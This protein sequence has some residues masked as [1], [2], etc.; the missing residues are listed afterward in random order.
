MARSSLASL[1][2]SLV[3]VTSNLTAYAQVLGV[4]FG[5]QYIKAAL[6]KPGIPLE[7]VLTKD[8]RRK[9][10]SAVAMKPSRGPL[11]PDMYPE[12]LYGSDAMALAPRFPGDVYPNLKKILGLPADDPAISEYCAR[13]PALNMEETSRGTAA[14]KSKAFVNDEAPWT[15]EELVAMQ[16]QSIQKNAETLAGSGSS[17]KSIVLT[18]PPFYTIEEKRAIQAAANLAGLKVLS[19][20]SD[21]LAVGLNYATSR[22]FPNINDGAKPEIHMV[23]DMG[24]GSTKASI[25]RFQSRNVKDIGK[26]NKTIQEVE[27]L[28]SGWDRSLGGDELNGLLVDDMLR[29]FVDSSAAK[30]AGV[31]IDAVKSHGRAVA[32]LFKEAERLRHVLSA[33]QQIGTSFEGL[34]DEIDFKY[35]IKR[36]YFEEMAQSYAD[37]V[38]QV[39]QHALNAAGL[40][41][42]QLDSIILHGGASRTP[43][44]QAQLTEIVGNPDKIRTNVNSDEAAVFGAGFRAA[45]IS[46]SFRVKEIRIGEAANYPISIKWTDGNGKDHTQRIWQATSFLGGS[47]K[48]ITF[49]NREDFS[50]TF[51]QNSSPIEVLMTKNLTASIEELKSKHGCTDETIQLKV[52]L[53]LASDNG[54]VNIVKMA[55][56]C[57]TE[58]PEKETFVDGVKNLF[59]FGN[60]KDGASEEQKVLNDVDSNG[61]ESADPTED[62]TASS[63][64]TSSNSDFSS[65]TTSSA[66]EETTLTESTVGQASDSANAEKTKRLVTINVDYEMTKAGIPNLSTTEFAS[67]RNRL[68]AFAT[69][70]RQRKL[71]EEALNTLEGYTYRVRDMLE[72][73]SFISASTEEFRTTLN[74]KTSEIS[75]WLYDDGA[76]APRDELQ[77]RLKELRDMVNPVL[78]RAEEAAERPQ[79]IADLKD[80]LKQSKDFLDNIR[81]SIVERDEWENSQAASSAASSSEFS[82]TTEISQASEDESAN[83]EDEKSDT[84]SA[85][86]S[87]GDIL[88]DR[89]PVPPLY[90]YEDLTELESLGNDITKW[91]EELETQ[92]NVLSA[93]DNPV[94]LVKDLKARREKLDKV[95]LDLAMKSVKN[96]E[97]RDKSKK[98]NGKSS[99]NKGRRASSPTKAKTVT[100][101]REKAESTLRP[102]D[103]DGNE[104][105]IKLNPDGKI[106]SQEELEEMLRNVREK[107]EKQQEKHDEL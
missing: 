28:G 73:V 21:G 16:L 107:V 23:F 49:S 51:I 20:I 46:P 8:S 30:K 37:R 35:S 66:F 65:S 36:A 74:E 89:G 6:V 7:I 2:L 41:V 58:E 98:P 94:L 45:E 25:L 29:Q 104:N 34:F 15:V 13:H 1:I 9:E 59:G 62:S 24:A 38:E 87:D 61:S 102:E 12:R 57:E 33:N 106:P 82:A 56:K 84:E 105:Y 75:D 18:V 32:K 100:A 5:T 40:D 27:V 95:G 93:T 86:M 91:L 101:N 81:K 64:S 76:D 44:V 31:E 22:T 47:S 68:K 60:K 88:E 52:G 97:N 19:L 39:V 67:S 85:A 10:T 90:T 92:Q 14:F 79:L 55:A 54:E 69:S 17:V 3:L 71:R 48:E 70:D 72:S 96:F 11:Q 4:D 103:V 99:S 63:D 78:N 43:F 77:K 53:R 42:S 50:I 26:F 80:A 83:L